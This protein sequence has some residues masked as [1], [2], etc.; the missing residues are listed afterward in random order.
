LHWIDDETQAL[1]NLLADSIATAKILLLVN[2]RPEYSHLWNSKSHYTQLRL[3]PLGR[4]SAVDMLQS[5][6]GDDAELEPLK[7]LII[8]KTEGNPLFMEETVE[9]LLDDGALVRDGEAVRLTKALSEL[10]IPPTVRAILAARIDRLPAVGKDLLQTLAVMGK[11]FPLDLVRAVAGGSPDEVGDLLAVLQLGEFIYEQ[12]AVGDIEYTFKHALTQEV[13]YNSILID[14]RKALHERIGVAIEEIFVDSLGD[15]LIQLADHYRRSANIEKAVEYQSKAA[16]RELMQSGYLGALRRL[17]NAL[18]L[19]AKLPDTKQRTELELDLQLDYVA[20]VRA[21]KGY[22]APEAG[23]AYLRARELCQEKGHQDQR[24]YRVLSGLHSFHMVRGEHPIALAYTDELIRLADQSR[25]EQFR[26][27]AH[28]SLGFSK[29]FMGEFAAAH[30][31]FELTIDFYQRQEARNTRLGSSDQDPLVSSLCYDAMTLWMLGYP[32]QA[33]NRVRDATLLARQLGHMFTLAWC[34]SQLTMYHTIRGSYDEADRTA[35]EGLA[36]TRKHGLTFLKTQIGSYGLMGLAARGKF[37]QAAATE[38]DSSESGY[39]GAGY[40]LAH[41]WARPIL[42][43]GFASLG[44]SDIAFALVAQSVELVERNQERYVEAEVYRIKGELLLGQVKD[45]SDTSEEFRK[46]AFAAD[47]SFR[48]AIEIARK[49]SARSWELRATAS[50]ARL[51]DRI[52]RRDEART[53]LAGIYNWFTEGL[54]S[55]DL[56]DAR[57]LLD[58]LSG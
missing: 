48:R 36:L 57:P 45:H 25:N 11:E 6:L 51:L 26:A 14:R 7:R 42:A 40:E 41:T 50:L 20:A 43:L 58:R 10:K 8:E 46:A 21:T 12:P 16:R 9:V 15:H 27:G 1:L 44:K 47:Q 34:L 35:S 30:S 55:P 53:M 19:Q 54:E 23:K 32:D 18:E 33:A 37:P 2:Y 52:G 29:F 3:D 13:A 56:K 28:H 38:R 22:W 49:Q 31:S 39:A 5:L 17:E 24:L 4:E